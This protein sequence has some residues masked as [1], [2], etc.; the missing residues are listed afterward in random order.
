GTKDQNW[1]QEDWFPRAF[2][3]GFR[4]SAVV[5]AA[6]IFRDISVKNIVNR[7]NNQQ[8][9]VQYFTTLEAAKGWIAPLGSPKDAQQV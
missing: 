2:A 4:R 8:F 5:V 3:V 7:I 9:E 6:D 1:M